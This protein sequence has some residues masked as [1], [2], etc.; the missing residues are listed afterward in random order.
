MN[1]QQTYIHHEKQEE[2][3]R[4]N[5][6]NVLD[7]IVAET[8]NELNPKPKTSRLEVISAQLS[9]YQK[10]LNQVNYVAEIKQADKSF[11][12]PKE[13]TMS[14][15]EEKCMKRR[16]KM[17]LNLTRRIQSVRRMYKRGDIDRY[18][19]DRLC[20]IWNHLYEQND[21]RILPFGKVQ[22]HRQITW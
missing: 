3:N 6:Y 19:F 10:A 21:P 16:N 13:P 2:I 8:L 1:N 7:S 12:K 5:V 14:Q 11:S 18:E 4:A 15:I 22:N 17:R 20:V 9:A